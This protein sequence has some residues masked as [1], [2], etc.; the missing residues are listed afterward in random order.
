MHIPRGHFYVLVPHQFLH[1]SDVDIIHYEIGS[2]GMP[3]IVEPEILYPRAPASCGKAPLPIPIRLA[4]RLR[5]YE[6]SN[7]L[8]IELVKE[9]TVG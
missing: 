8:L 3:Q 7:P 5:E 9:R 4:V 6:L 2:K 1:D